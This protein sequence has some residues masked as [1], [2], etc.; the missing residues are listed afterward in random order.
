MFKR[1]NVPFF[2]PD[3]FGA[4]HTINYRTSFL[5]NCASGGPAEHAAQLDQRIQQLG[6]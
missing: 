1:I 5:Q 6:A 4:S 2:C 3:D